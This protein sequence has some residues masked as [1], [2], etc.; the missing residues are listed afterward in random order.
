MCVRIKHSMYRFS[1]EFLHQNITWVALLRAVLAR[2]Y[3]RHDYGSWFH[4][5][6]GGAAIIL[7]GLPILVRA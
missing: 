7:N 1:I 5:R 4:F 6:R 3:C 2:F